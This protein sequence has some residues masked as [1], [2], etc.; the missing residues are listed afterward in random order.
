MLCQVNDVQGVIITKALCVRILVLVVLPCLR[1][2]AVVERSS[3]G[4]M[5]QLKLTCLLVFLL[6]LD[7]WVVLVGNLN[8]VFGSGTSGDLDH[9]VEDIGFRVFRLEAKI[10]P[11]TDGF[12]VL[13]Q[14]MTR[15]IVWLVSIRCFE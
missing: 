1:D 6:V 12:T 5:A 9:S 2:H 11:W 15:S 10:M 8:L 7:N 4:I 13:Q 14:E 3:N